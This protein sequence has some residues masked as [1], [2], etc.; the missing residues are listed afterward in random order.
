MSTQFS[1]EQIKSGFA[2]SGYICNDSIAMTM[3]L[4]YQ[5]EKKIFHFPS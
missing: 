3:F 2:Q 1:V 5:L 4:A